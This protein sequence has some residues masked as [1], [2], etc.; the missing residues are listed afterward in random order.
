M[1]TVVTARDASNCVEDEGLAVDSSATVLI[2]AVTA[3]AVETIASRIHRRSGRSE[4]PFI[5]I[6]AGELPRSGHLLDSAF[7]QLFA[8][9]RGG[10]VLLNDVDRMPSG[11]QQ[12]LLA[13]LDELESAGDP[14]TS[15]VLAGT[16]V[17]L[18]NRVREGSFSELLFYRL[19]VLHLQ[20]N[21]ADTACTDGQP[22]GAEG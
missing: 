22:L 4:F 9:A 8:A 21:G 11:A 1:M 16:T 18:F 12:Q 19:N 7:A 20:S 3:T 2:S 6:S 10:S 15:R 13:F 5:P 14:D 17:W